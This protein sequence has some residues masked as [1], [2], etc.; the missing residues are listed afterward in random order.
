MDY[1]TGIVPELFS[2]SSY[3]HLKIT[4]EPAREMLVLIA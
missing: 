3:P 2:G 4:Y 1:A